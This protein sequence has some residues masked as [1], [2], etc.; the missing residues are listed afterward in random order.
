MVV[1]VAVDRAAK[2]TEKERIVSRTSR[3]RP[4]AILRVWRAPSG[5]DVE[6][7]AK[8][9]TIFLGMETDTEISSLSRFLAT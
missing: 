4:H 1:D 8:A 2:A 5:P 9:A 6:R 3:K 7:L